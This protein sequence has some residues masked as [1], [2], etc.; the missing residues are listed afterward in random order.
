MAS[1]LTRR[2]KD[3]YRIL[4]GWGLPAVFSAAAWDVGRAE[5]WGLPILIWLCYELFFAPVLCGVETS[6][7]HPCK[8][9]AY[10]RIR[11]CNEPSH[12]VY[13]RDQLL[14]L[15]GFR[16]RERQITAPARKP[17]RNRL[18]QEDEQPEG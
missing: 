8:Q 18:P 4:V 5:L 13:K 9:R 10:G 1:K 2:E 11:A 15:F 7:K 3:R 12:H 16:V 17:R 14:L 6:R